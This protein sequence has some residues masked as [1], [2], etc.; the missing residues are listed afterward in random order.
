MSQENR[1][2]LKEML[3]SGE[4]RLQP[5]TFSQRE[6]W[7]ASPVPV[8]ESS[9]HICTFMEVRGAITDAECLAA[10]QLVVDRQEVMRLSILPGKDQPLQFIRKTRAAVM[11]ISTL[12]ADPDALEEKLRTI[13]EEPFD[14]LKG[15]L[16]R[17][18]VIRRGPDDLVLAFAIHH[19]IADG[20]TLG[21]FVED[22]AAAYLQVRMGVAGALPDVPLSYTAWAAAERDFWNPE[23]LEQRGQFWI[24]RLAGA[25][26]LW[27]AV[28]NDAPRVLARDV[29]F[30]GSN[31]TQAVRNLARRA[32]ATLFSTLLTAFQLALSQWTGATDIVVGTPVANRTKQSVRETMGYCSGNVPIRGE[33]RAD[34]TLE[35]SVREMHLNAMDAF[36]NAMPFAELV[37][38]VGDPP[39]ADH[40]PIFDVR[41][42]LQ[43]HPIPDITVPGMSVHLRMRSTGTARF[44]LGCE[45]TESGDELEVVWVYRPKVFSRADVENI[46][47]LFVAVLEGIATAPESRAGVLTTR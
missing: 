40:N 14:L 25:P 45:I 35:E 21:V 31:V 6:L 36:A 16:Y 27:D 5:L 7:E 39:S 24:E 37:R 26:R 18:E 20:W 10:L 29:S 33:I 23:K 4:A 43:N 9:N 42:A 11:K 47:N 3:A 15:P 46:G 13:F 1:N 41:F 2:R 22:L 12:S 17:V 28:T 38:A 19:A 30:I 34:R 44:D 8:A 32:D